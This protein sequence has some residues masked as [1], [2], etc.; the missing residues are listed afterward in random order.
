MDQKTVEAEIRIEEKAEEA[1]A[2]EKEIKELKG[3][4]TRISA[5]SAALLTCEHLERLLKCYCMN[6]DIL[7]VAYYFLS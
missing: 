4:E 2:L 6:V 1:S 5:A 7:V 3:Q